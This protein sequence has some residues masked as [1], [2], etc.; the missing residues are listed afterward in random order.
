[1]VETGW[2]APMDLTAVFFSM[3]ILMATLLKTRETW[4]LCCSILILRVDWP[5]FVSWNYLAVIG[6]HL[7]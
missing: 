7:L 2:L 6:T 5:L 3:L 4:W 1:M